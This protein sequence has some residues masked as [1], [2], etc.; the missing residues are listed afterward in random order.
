MSILLIGNGPSVLQN[1]CGALIDEFDLVVR[2]NNFEL[3]GYGDYVGHKSDILCRRAC[4][5]VKWWPISMF[6]LVY[7]FVPLCKWTPWMPPVVQ[8]VKNFY[9]N[10]C[11]IVD[12][13]LTA[14]TAARLKQY[15]PQT[16][17]PSIGML[18]IDYFVN[19]YDEVITIHGFDHLVET[20]GQIQH[21]Y[22]TKPKDSR[23][24]DGGVEREYINGLINDGKLIKLTSIISAKERR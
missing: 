24:H 21:Y 20:E 12:T 15:D 18:A 16:K 9:R 8:S 2:F 10:K 14:R 11:I 5:D 7:C 6:K 13:D 22:P 4:D 19:Y 1:K 23:Y 3:E 17:W